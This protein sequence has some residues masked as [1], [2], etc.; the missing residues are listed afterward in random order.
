MRGELIL[1]DRHDV[2]PILT[3]FSL[4][5]LLLHCFHCCTIGVRTFSLT[6]LAGLCAAAQAAVR[7]AA[8]ARPAR[9][10]GLF[11]TAA[12]GGGA[13]SARPIASAAR[14][15]S[16]PST[17]SAPADGRGRRR[18]SGQGGFFLP[19]APLRADPAPPG[20]IMKIA[21][22]KDGLLGYSF[23]DRPRP[24]ATPRR[25][26]R[27]N[28]KLGITFTRQAAAGQQRAIKALEAAEPPLTRYIGSWGACSPLPRA[29]ANTKRPDDID[30]DSS[31]Q[32]TQ[33]PV[34]GAAF[35]AVPQR[36]TLLPGEGG[37]ELGACVS[38]RGHG[39]SAL[40]QAA[41]GDSCVTEGRRQRGHGG[42]RDPAGRQEPA[43]SAVQR[44]LD[45][46]AELD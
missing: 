37:G 12:G 17:A 29:L 7:V 31:A 46:L 6:A 39:R 3:L 19:N 45:K 10:R 21:M 25:V 23:Q 24:L 41:S 18:T 42:R 36:A 5:V 44:Q 15:A 20:A 30:D 33:G 43:A 32:V 26:M 22:A 11:G 38:C 2:V 8:L 27:S 34:R 16:R 40:A 14:T 1:W 4:F 35:E 9:C 13:R 28:L